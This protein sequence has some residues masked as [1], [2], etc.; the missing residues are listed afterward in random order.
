[1]ENAGAA[2]V[3][4]SPQTVAELDSLINEATVSGHRYTD[5]LMASTDSEKD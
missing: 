2:D 5:A 3:S 4:L 1:V